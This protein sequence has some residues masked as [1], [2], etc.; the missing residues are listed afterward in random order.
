M[1]AFFAV[2]ALTVSFLSNMFLYGKEEDIFERTALDNRHL[3]TVTAWIHVS[4]VVLFTLATFK[5]IADLR[6]DAKES[7]IENEKEK[8]LV[9]DHEWLRARTLHVRGLLPKDRCGTMLKNELEGMIRPIGG[10]VLDV[11]VIPDF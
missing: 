10:R 3:N 4:L 8:C 7:F 5:C 6:E 1:T 11:V 9:K 2:A